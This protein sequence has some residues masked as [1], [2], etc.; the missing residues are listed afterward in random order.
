VKNEYVQRVR[1]LKGLDGEIPAAGM[2]TIGTT[3]A[4]RKEALDVQRRRLLRLR[5]EEV[6][7]DDVLHRIQHELDLEDLGLS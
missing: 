5:N 6:I 3:K 2:A 1:S 4:L 7:G